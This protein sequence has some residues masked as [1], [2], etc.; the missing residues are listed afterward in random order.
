MSHDSFGHKH[1]R[2]SANSIWQ[3]KIKNYIHMKITT[4]ILSFL[5]LNVLVLNAQT[6]QSNIAEIS[7]FPH[8]AQITRE[9]NVNLKKGKQTLVFK[10][11]ANNIQTNSIRVQSSV[12][13]ILSVKHSNNY[14]EHP[15]NS[16]KHKI[17]KDSLELVQN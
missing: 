8:S 2:I 9:A 1:Q 17:Y 6:V 15:Q 13:K 11:L 14:M 16:A 7:L 10:S 4:Y 5:L 12:G 3:L